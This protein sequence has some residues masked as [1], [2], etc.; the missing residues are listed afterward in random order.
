MRAEYYGCLD[1]TLN[2][3]D[4]KE[5]IEGKIIIA[6][7]D[8]RDKL[9]V[10]LKLEEIQERNLEITQNHTQQLKFPFNTRSFYLEGYHNSPEILRINGWD[11]RLKKQEFLKWIKET[12]KNPS[13]EQCPFWA[14]GLEYDCCIDRIHINYFTV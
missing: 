11:L 14:R 7:T 9:K 6:I 12:D 4:A 2:P 8:Y 13:S 1:I 10:Q 5:L 3:L